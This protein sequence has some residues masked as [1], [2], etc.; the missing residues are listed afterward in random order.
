M[1]VKDGPLQ[2]YRAT[3]TVNGHTYVIMTKERPP[4]ICEEC[5]TTAELRPYGKNNKK[6]CFDC[7]M[8][9]PKETKR[10]MDADIIDKLK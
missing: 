5:S 4:G 3:Y 9:D 2:E 1:T 6:I 8:K 7:G 10:Q